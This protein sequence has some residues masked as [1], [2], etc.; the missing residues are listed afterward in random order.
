MLTFQFNRNKARNF[1]EV[2][3]LGL[4][5]FTNPGSIPGRG[6]RFHRLCGMAKTKQNTKP[7][8]KKKNNKFPFPIFDQLLI[9]NDWHNNWLPVEFKQLE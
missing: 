8:K 3:W 7:N 9:S 2:Q 6:T 4:G 5:E 1:L